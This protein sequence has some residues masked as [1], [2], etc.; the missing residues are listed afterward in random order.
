M[1]DDANYPPEF[2]AQLR[3]IAG[4][5]AVRAGPAIALLDP[6]VDPRNLA[7]GLMVRPIDAAQTGKILALCAAARV[8][9]VA[10]GGRTGLAGGA[11]TS[12][13]EVIV[14]LDRMTSVENFNPQARTATVQAGCTLAG[15][16]EVIAP[17]GLAAGIDL[18]ARGTATIGGMVATNAGGI[19][20][21]RYGTMRE[22]V[23]GLEVALPSGQ[24]ISD[25]SRVRKDNTGVPLRQLFIGSEGILGVITPVSYTHLTLTTIYSV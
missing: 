23:L 5:D 1:T 9:V 2:V 15:L 21:F 17:L 24:V 22:R 8:G 6:G 10:Q 13:G 25:L 16:D 14:S 20:A 4:A 18:G 11:C 7:A 3:A 19:D 12:R